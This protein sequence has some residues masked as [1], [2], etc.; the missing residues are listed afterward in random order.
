MH[1]HLAGFRHEDIP[2]YYKPRFVKQQT[3]EVVK[4][5]PVFD[6]WHRDTVEMFAHCSRADLKLWNFDRNEFNLPDEEF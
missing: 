1:E 3:V 6:D 2:K 5:K 4:A